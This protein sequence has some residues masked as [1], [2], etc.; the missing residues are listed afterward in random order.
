MLMERVYKQRV[1]G[2]N[3]LQLTGGSNKQEKAS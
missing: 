1:H 2:K 3:H